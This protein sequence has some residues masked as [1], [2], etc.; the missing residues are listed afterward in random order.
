M[1]RFWGEHALTHRIYP[2]MQKLSDCIQPTPEARSPTFVQKRKK[3]K[4]TKQL[5]THSQSR[6]MGKTTFK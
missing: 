1:N 3:K 2:N 4:N 5:N 6:I